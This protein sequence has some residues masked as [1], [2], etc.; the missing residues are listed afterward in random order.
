LLQIASLRPHTV[1][2]DVSVRE[3]SKSF[4]TVNAIRVPRGILIVRR[5]MRVD[6]ELY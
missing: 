5:A 6:A 3:H 1:L 2:H 4:A